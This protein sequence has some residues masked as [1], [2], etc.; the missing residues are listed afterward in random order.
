MTSPELDA[1]LGATPRRAGF[2]WAS[3]VA[4][5]LAIGVA[6]ML[7]MR[8]LNGPDLPYYT[9]SVERGDVTPT[10]SLHGT[11]H[12]AGETDLRAEQDGLVLAV[13]GPADGPVAAGQVLARM[14]D[15][16]LL[17][18]VAQARATLA[19]DESEADRARI[20]L[21]EATAKLDRYE[22]VWR[23]S[24]HRA[25][26]LNEM[27][28]ARADVARASV[29]LSSANAKA[30]ADEAVIRSAQV[31][32]ARASVVAP[33]AGAVVAR[34]VTPGQQ[35]TAGTPLFTLATNTDRLTVSV[36]V[37]AAQAMRI[38]PHAKARV[39]APA[40]SDGPRG[41]TLDHIEAAPASGDGQRMAILTL[42]GPAA[43]LHPGMAVTVDIDMPARKNVLLVPD[44]ALA[45]APPGKRAGNA[46]WLL[47]SDNQ[48]RQI[49]V[50]V[51]ASD[52]KRTEV[53]AETLSP[54]AQVITGW[55]HSSPAQAGA[56]S[57]A[58]KP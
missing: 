16:A 57:P 14:D 42:D 25:P 4:L 43:P 7:L 56:S 29:A 35:V 37:T 18:D 17:A 45:F 50:A 58:G 33:F 12:G 19:Q 54:G 28:G 32:A 9:A 11:L 21:A 23:R 31:R 55:R 1:F 49:P 44:S 3:L 13:P 8:F 41:A 48:P 10:L 6:F 15:T 52:G 20:A 40:L 39:L 2:A 38:A 5:V 51:E 27:E 34:L 46:V 47:G 36:P 53:I 22:N 30:S 24:Q 26:S